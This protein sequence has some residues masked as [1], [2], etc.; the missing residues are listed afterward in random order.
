MARVTI[1]AVET[2]GGYPTAG[3]VAAETAADA[4]NFNQT[5]HT[6]RNFIIIGRNSGSSTRAITITSVADSQGR[7]GNISDTL[8]N[9]QRKVW[10]PFEA[11]GWKQPSDGMLYFQAAHAEV[12]FS[13]IRF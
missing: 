10:G 13:V 8:T 9:G 6:G 1:A 12:L 11:E 7:T 4:S 3:A 5:P 2:V